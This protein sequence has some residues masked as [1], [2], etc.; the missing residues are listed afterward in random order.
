MGYIVAVH[1]GTGN[2]SEK[3]ITLLKNLCE[4]VCNEVDCLLAEGASCETAAIAGAC[5]LEESPLTNAGVGSSIT[6]NKEIR[7]EASLCSSRWGF[8]SAGDL[9]DVKH[10]IKVVEM[11][12]KETQEAGP[13][14]IPPRIMVGQ[15]AVDRYRKF[16]D[17]ISPSNLS[18]RQSISMFHRAEKYFSGRKRRRRQRRHRKWSMRQAGQWSRQG[19]APGWRGRR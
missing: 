6:C 2:C 13:K 7:T 8:H 1:T 11:M 17:S 5:L 19:V 10:P 14:Y 16:D 9:P 3:T 4:T 18:T 12:M 15:R